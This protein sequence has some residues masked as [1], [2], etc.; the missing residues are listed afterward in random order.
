MAARGRSWVLVVDCPP[1]HL[2][3]HLAIFPTSTG[4]TNV[5]RL[6]A[7][8]EFLC[9][10]DA[11]HRVFDPL[12]ADWQREWR[13]APASTIMRARIIASGSAALLWSLVSCIVSGGIVMT[14]AVIIKTTIVLALS[15]LT[16]LLMQIGFNAV[17]LS[18]DFPLEMRFWMALPM[19]MPLVIPLAMLP[20]LMLLRAT[21][22]VT[23]GA[24]T[25]LI[26][27]GALLTYVTT[28]WLTPLA[29]GDVRD[30]LYEEFHQRA[31]AN[32]QAGRV[33]YPG[34]AVRQVRQTTAEQRAAQRE[35]WRRNPLY[36]KAQEE[37]TGPQWGR[38][39]IATALLAIATGALGWAI[40]GLRQ[41]GGLSAVAWWT[42]AWI[43]VMI[44]DGRMLYPGNG[45]T[46]YVGRAPYWMP[47]AVFGSAAVV[48]T[49]ST[50]RREQTT[51][52]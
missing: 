27:A 12:V 23:N 36:I 47:L 21:G 39:T 32:D 4:G 44:L 25:T 29:Q 7:L 31:V 16:L 19:V 34:T 33:Q 2:G 42:F 28:A 8:V 1:C 18:I 51:L 20:I 24:A 38:L 43:T 48:A 40:G 14:R 10:A 13:L 49:L 41:T 52:E 11:R 15:T 46:T 3:I 5:T 22:Q 45:I 37:R 26:C 35:R 17:A 6:L 30:A 9:G 50:S